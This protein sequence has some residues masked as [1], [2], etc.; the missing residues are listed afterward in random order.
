MCERLD[1][2]MADLLPESGPDLP[3]WHATS[4]KAELEPVPIIQHMEAAPSQWVIDLTYLAR[5][6]LSR[7]VL[8][9]VLLVVISLV[10]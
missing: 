7:V 3:S 5:A 1:A 9:L 4:V 10:W 2:V 8:A 6:L